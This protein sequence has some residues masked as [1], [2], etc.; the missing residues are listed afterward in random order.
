MKYVNEKEEKQALIF[1]NKAA[2]IAINSTCERAKCG[3]IIVKNEEIIGNGFNSPPGNIENQRRCSYA[4]ESYNKKVTDKTCC[5]HA[6]Q[7][8]IM[9]ALRRNKEKL[10]GSILYFIRLDKNG[11]PSNAGKPYCTI[12]SK[13]VLDSGIKEFV[14]FEKNRIVVY[15]TE[16]YNKISFR[17]GKENESIN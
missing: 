3:S 15:D 8:A 1:I 12:C 7:R 16:E 17:F 5:V 14:L 9:D 11:N 10:L 6:E 13:M 2:E 4:K